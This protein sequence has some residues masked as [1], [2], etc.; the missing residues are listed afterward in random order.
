M[1]IFAITLVTAFMVDAAAQPVVTP[2]APAQ[3][4]QNTVTAP[5]CGANVPDGFMDIKFGTSLENA[6][7]LLATR[8]YKFVKREGWQL[9]LNNVPL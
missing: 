2:V 1:L 6:E 3:S 8:N 5:L 4:S 7:Q 9:I